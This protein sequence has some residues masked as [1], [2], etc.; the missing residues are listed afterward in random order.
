MDSDRAVGDESEEG[1]A[2]CDNEM[3]EKVESERVC[4]G[5]PPP[6]GEASV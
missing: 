3:E 5:G 1:E 2:M 4:E 6:M